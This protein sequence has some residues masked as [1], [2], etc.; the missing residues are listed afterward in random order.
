VWGPRILQ[1]PRA[2]HDEANTP[3]PLGRPPRASAGEGTYDDS[4]FAGPTFRIRPLLLANG[5]RVTLHLWAVPLFRDMPKQLQDAHGV[6]FVYDIRDCESH[7]NVRR[8]AGHVS[9]AFP[10]GGARKPPAAFLL[11]TKLDL[12]EK[13]AVTRAEGEALGQQLGASVFV[14]VSAKDATDVE[15]GECAEPR[16]ARI[17][18]P[19][20]LATISL[21]AWPVASSSIS[22]RAAMRGGRFLQLEEPTQLPRWLPAA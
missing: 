19:P 6:V 3:L 12:A 21:Y 20:P 22:L 16:A 14:E 18:P 10:A 8:W 4:Y 11:A 5:E 1:P 17:S 9:S 15:A 2:E 7:A 13:R